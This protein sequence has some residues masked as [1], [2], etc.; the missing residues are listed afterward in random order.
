MVMVQRGHDL[1][2]DM[3]QW[4]GGEV[5]RCQHQPSDSIGLESTLLWAAYQH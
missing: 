5:S 4:V 3:L 2:K 1:L